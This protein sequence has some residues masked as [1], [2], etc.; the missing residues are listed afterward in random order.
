MNP[1]DTESKKERIVKTALKLFSHKGFHATT[2]KDI[3]MESGVTEGLIFYYFGDKRKLLLHI[4]R[5]FSFAA[6]VRKDTEQLTPASM[7]ESLFQYGLSYSRFLHRH[8][9]YIML[10]WSPEM[11]QDEEVS[12]EVLHLIEGIGAAGSSLLKRG[13]DGLWDD[14]PFETV[15]LMMTS[16]ILV[17]FMMQSRFGGSVGVESDEELIRKLAGILAHGFKS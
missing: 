17:H 2:T 13:T 14:S 3:A 12:R 4:V 8:A 15:V 9:D 6:Q 7:E 10:L 5:N 16:S 1:K 11:I